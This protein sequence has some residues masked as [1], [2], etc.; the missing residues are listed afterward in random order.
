MKKLFCLLNYFF[1]F[2]KPQ[3]RQLHYGKT[4]ISEK[5]YFFIYWNTKYG[6]YI[7]IPELKKYVLGRNGAVFIPTLNEVTKLTI[8][9]CNTWNKVKIKAQPETIDI[10]AE[11]GYFLEVKQKELIPQSLSFFT[12]ISLQL[13]PAYHNEIKQPDIYLHQP[14]LSIIHPDIPSSLSL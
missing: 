5:G 10:P 8:T 9:V 2:R 11:K 12:S 7:S 3:I 4:L 1:I 13:L 6:T 14:S